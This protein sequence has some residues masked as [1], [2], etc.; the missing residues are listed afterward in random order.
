[1]YHHLAI[2]VLLWAS[3]Q[4]LSQRFLCPHLT[5]AYIYSRLT[6]LHGSRSRPS[7][8]QARWFLRTTRIRAYSPKPVIQR[9]HNMSDHLNDRQ[10]V[11]S[12]IC[13]VITDVTSICLAVSSARSRRVSAR[14]SLRGRVNVIAADS[15]TRRDPLIQ[16]PRDRPQVNMTYHLRTGSD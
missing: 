9:P 10:A 13:G 1:M 11:L 6:A 4:V 7:S 14:H 15:Y 12:D 3:Y 8:P 2:D 16:G 5:P